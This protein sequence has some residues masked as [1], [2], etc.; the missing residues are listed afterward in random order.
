MLVRKAPRRWYSLVHV[1]D[2]LAIARHDHLEVLRA[3][4]RRSLAIP[5]SAR[6]ARAPRASV[7]PDGAVR[8]A[9]AVGAEAGLARW[10][11][12][13]GAHHGNGHLL[14]LGPIR[15]GVGPDTIVRIPS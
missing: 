8:T 14:H 3:R 11:D 1:S 12:L 13:V 7:P 9:V 6:G 15:Q 5:A 2:G 10:T 4:L